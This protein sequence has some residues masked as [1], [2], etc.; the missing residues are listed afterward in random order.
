MKTIITYGTFDL[1]HVGHVRL[2]QRLSALGD[3]LV[4]GISTDEFNDEKGKRSFSSFKERAEIVSSCR[5][6]S[7]VFAEEGW[8][9]KREDII[10]F[11]AD[12]FVMGDDWLGKFDDLG[13]I[14]DVQYVPRTEDISTTAIKKSL[15][16][17]NAPELDRL[18]SSLH[19]VL[20]IVRAMAEK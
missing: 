9:Q 11:N 19:D 13:D 15:S 17:I 2:L 20:E 1:F 7:E 6:V 18:E 10:R 4:V 16:K 8:G 3:R 14:C 12:I 5:F